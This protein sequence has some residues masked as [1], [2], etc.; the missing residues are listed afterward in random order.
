MTISV[1]KCKIVVWAGFIETCDQ[2]LR[3]NGICE[4]TVPRPMGVARSKGPM[5]G[6]QL[7][8]LPLQLGHEARYQGDCA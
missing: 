6:S 7:W 5:T 2:T 1:K 4:H 3:S 8:H